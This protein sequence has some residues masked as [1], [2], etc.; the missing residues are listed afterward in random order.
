MKSEQ[1]SQTNLE[2]WTAYQRMGLRLDA[3]LAQELARTGLSQ[4]DYEILSALLES[5]NDSMRAISLR[6]GIEWEK[7]RLSHQLRRMEQRGLI[8]R[9]ACEEDN[10]GAVVRITERGRELAI[11]AKACYEHA[12]QRYFVQALSE[13]ELQQLKQISQTLL[14]HLDNLLPLKH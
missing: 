7:S 8:R 13:G 3:I 9:E 1:L 14:G 10:R 6:C 4:A 12:I 11:E 5:P 2:I